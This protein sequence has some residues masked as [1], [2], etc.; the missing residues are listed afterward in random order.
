MRL[1][2][3]GAYGITKPCTRLLGALKDL[4]LTYNIERIDIHEFPDVG[5][6]RKINIVPTVMLIDN[7]EN[8]VRRIEGPRTKEVFKE[9][10]SE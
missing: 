6:S 3:F 8:E 5:E 4:S 2:K 9:W 7:D 10:L 1:I